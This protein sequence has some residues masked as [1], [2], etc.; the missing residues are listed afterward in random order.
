MKHLCT[1]NP[2]PKLNFTLPGEGFETLP[3]PWFYN[4]LLDDASGPASEP[5][6][7]GWSICS[8][9][10]AEA[11]D[12]NEAEFCCHDAQKLMKMERQQ[13]ASGLDNHLILQEFK[14]FRVCVC[15]YILHLV[16]YIYINKFAGHFHSWAPQQLW[17]LRRHETDLI[18]KDQK[19]L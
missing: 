3:R 18:P 12:A 7:C 14:N 4:V 11:T 15:E 16:L 17:S 1:Q 10:K 6:S 13:N 9:E 2:N 19:L 8:D 5:R